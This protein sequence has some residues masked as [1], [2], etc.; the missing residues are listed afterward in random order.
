MTI[1]YCLRF[2]TPT[3]CKAR[4]LYLYPPGTG[5]S[6]YT[7]GTGFPFSLVLLLARLCDPPKPVWTLRRMEKSLSSTC[8]KFNF[9]RPVSRPS[10]DHLSYPSSASFNIGKRE[11]KNIY[12]LSI[13]LSIYLPVSL[14]ICL[15]ARSSVFPCT[16]LSVRPPD[17]VSAMSH[18]QK[19]NRK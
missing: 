7:P 9:C 13:Y 15:P 8:W 10:L 2:E 1:F 5:W 3:A 6:S 18:F 11:G 12:L 19:Y 17:P 4:S 16:C 14:Y